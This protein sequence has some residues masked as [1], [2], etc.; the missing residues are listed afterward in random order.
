MAKSGV[1]TTGAGAT[2]GKE[3]EKTKPGSRA[4]PGIRI[5]FVAYVV[6]PNKLM[7][8]KKYRFTYRDWCEMCVWECKLVTIPGAANRFYYMDTLTL[9]LNG[10]L[11]PRQKAYDTEAPIPTDMMMRREVYTYTAWG[12]T[13]PLM[14]LVIPCDG[15]VRVTTGIT[16]RFKLEQT[17]D[18]MYTEGCWAFAEDMSMY[19]FASI[20][21]S[22]ENLPCLY[23]YKPA[24][25]GDTGD[26]AGGHAEG[27][28]QAR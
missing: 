9:V 2:G 3:K 24:T 4:Q 1:G 8:T 11:Q 5:G 23:M 20:S 22:E 17:T 21:M 26:H 19:I 15:M 13:M 28:H 18:L 25:N 10:I 14:K 27:V 6:T 16:H 7:T 12:D